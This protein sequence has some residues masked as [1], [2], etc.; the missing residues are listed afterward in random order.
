MS[1]PFRKKIK[2]IILRKTLDKNLKVWYNGE[3]GSLRASASRQSKKCWLFTSTRG[4]IAV[5]FLVNQ[6][7]GQHQRRAAT[8]ATDHHGQTLFGKPTAVNVVCW[9]LNASFLTQIF[10]R[11]S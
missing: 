7:R 10:L 5:P 9:H 3:F 4:A 6:S 8:S 11:S 2:K 1:T